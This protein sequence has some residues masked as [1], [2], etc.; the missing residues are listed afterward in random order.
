MHLNSLPSK[1]GQTNRAHEG[2]AMWRF[3]SKVTRKDAVKQGATE[4][5][6]QEERTVTFA[7]PDVTLRVAQ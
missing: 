2:K 5:E 7:T 6:K 4:M 1:E 3:G